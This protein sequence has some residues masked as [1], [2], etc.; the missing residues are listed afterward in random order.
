MKTDKMIDVMDTAL[1]KDFDDSVKYTVP[2]I[3]PEKAEVPVTIS[4]EHEQVKTNLYNVSNKLMA[5]MDFLV[6]NLEELNQPSGMI[7][8]SPVSEICSVAKEIGTI[9]DKIFKYAG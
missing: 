6:N 4:K 2:M 9:N 7:K 8:S 5:V 3:M 1:D